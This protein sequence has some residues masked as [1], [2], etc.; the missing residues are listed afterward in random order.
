MKLR[1]SIL[2]MLLCSGLVIALGLTACGSDDDDEVDCA[3]ALTSIQRDACVN[4]A[5]AGID[6]FRTCLA[7]CIDEVCEEGCQDTFDADTDAC[8]P[9]AT[10][11]T[12]ECGC[13]ICGVTFEE[14]VGSATPAAGRRNPCVCRAVPCRPGP[15]PH[16]RDRGCPSPAAA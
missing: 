6:A 4:A 16:R 5:T 3:K 2:A 11:L 9:A 7:G 10:I 15:R 8:E 12:D 14:C 1:R 13:Q